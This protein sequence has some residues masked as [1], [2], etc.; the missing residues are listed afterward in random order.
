MRI[1]NKEPDTTISKIDLYLTTGEVARLHGLLGNMLTDVRV[2]DASVSDDGSS[3]T[4]KVHLYNNVESTG[5]DPRQKT[6]IF[7]DR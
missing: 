6:I 1:H 3:H 5:F 7:E 4:L 2:K